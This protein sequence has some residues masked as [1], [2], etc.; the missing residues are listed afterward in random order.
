MKDMGKFSVVISGLYNNAVFDCSVHIKVGKDNLNSDSFSLKKKL[1][2]SYVNFLF[3][4]AA[5]ILTGNMKNMTINITIQHMFHFNIVSLK[6]ASCKVKVDLSWLPILSFFLQFDAYIKH[7]I[8][9]EYFT[10]E[11]HSYIQKCVMHTL[12]PINTYTYAQLHLHNNYCYGGK[13]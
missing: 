13:R 5:L 4:S 7:I 12:P 6:L 8:L 2:R 9:Q 11:I 10:Y 1:N 3:C